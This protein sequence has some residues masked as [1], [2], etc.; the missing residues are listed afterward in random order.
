MGVLTED[1][2][3]VVREQRLAFV[4]TVCPD[5]TP[6]V[7]PK[8]TI[9]VLDDERLAFIDLR[10]PGTIANLRANSA[11]EVNVVDQV[12]RKGYRF[13]G[14]AEIV[15]EG[16]RLR[17]LLA[18]YEADGSGMHAEAGRRARAVVV[19][20]VERAAPLVSPGYDWVDGEEEMRAHW[21][22][23]WRELEESRA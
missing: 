20:D 23:Y 3:R 4:A 8:G 6:N 11:V 22:E 7:S 10:S 18:Y 9:A 1:M 2:K 14:R 21:L 13:K 15:E 12:V 5:G 19:V 17:E 16:P